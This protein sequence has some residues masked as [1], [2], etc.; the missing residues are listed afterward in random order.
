MLVRNEEGTATR[1]NEQSRL[2]LEP[3]K[4]QSERNSV[5]SEELSSLSRHGDREGRKG[6]V[7]G[8]DVGMKRRESWSPVGGGS[9]GAE[10]EKAGRFRV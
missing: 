7:Q 10:E 4:P 1:H 2:A 6:A 3:I 5:R 8:V 9:L